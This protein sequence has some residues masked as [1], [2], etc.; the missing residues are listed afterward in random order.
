M[1]S[2]TSMGPNVGSSIPGTMSLSPIAAWSLASA[3]R[4][5]L[6]GAAG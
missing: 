1:S 3:G 5:G 6:G 2:M 4:V